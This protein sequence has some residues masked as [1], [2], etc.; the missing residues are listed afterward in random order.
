MKQ[1]SKI[2]S[3]EHKINELISHLKDS[4]NSKREVEEYVLIL[5]KKKKDEDKDYNKMLEKLE[6]Y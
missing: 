6:T 4:E 5:Q 2:E 1:N 3:M